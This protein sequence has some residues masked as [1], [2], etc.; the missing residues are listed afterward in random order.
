[1]SE[2]NSLC[3]IPPIRNQLCKILDDGFKIIS[4]IVRMYTIIYNIFNGNRIQRQTLFGES[5]S[6]VI[7]CFKI[8]TRLI[9]LALIYFRVDKEKYTIFIFL[10]SILAFVCSLIH[11]ILY[12]QGSW[13]TII[14]RLPITSY[15]TSQMYFIFCIFWKDTKMLHCLHMT[16]YIIYMTISGIWKQSRS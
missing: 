1:M 11:N 14:K 16:A 8:V 3:S 6:G 12:C 7:C 9:E 15:C 10:T 5:D 2:N 13:W 4:R